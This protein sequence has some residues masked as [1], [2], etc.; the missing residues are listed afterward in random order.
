MSKAEEITV[1][2]QVLELAKDLDE[3]EHQEVL[4]RLNEIYEY[5]FLPWGAEC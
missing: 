5:W 1:K 2:T 3:M 4:D